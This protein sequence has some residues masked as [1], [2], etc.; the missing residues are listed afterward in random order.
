LL[1]QRRNYRLVVRR[2]EE[3]LGRFPADP[4]ATRAHYQLADSYRQLASQ[5]NQNAIIGEGMTAENRQHHV[6]EHRLWL[7]KAAKEFEEL[8][9]FLKKPE[10]RGHLSPEQQTRVPFI[11]ARCRFELGEYDKALETY[12][13]LAER[14]AGRREGLEALGG[15]VS[16]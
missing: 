16:C 10:A 13:E 7:Q 6:G 1:Y 5:E 11:L 12:E 8:D 2:L 14:Y 15:T 4:E 3:A 9:K